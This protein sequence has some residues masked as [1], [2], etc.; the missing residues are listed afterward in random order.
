M[1]I[2]LYSMS[3]VLAAGLT[4]AYAHAVLA[5]QGYIGSLQSALLLTAGVAGLFAGVQLAY[6]T[7]LNLVAPSRSG[8]PLFMEAVSNGASVVLLPYLLGIAIPWPHPKLAEVEVLVLLAAF[9]GLHAAVK[10]F[11]LFAALHV[12]PGYRVIA[13]PWAAGAFISLA[14]G[15]LCLQIFA[16][17]LRNH[18]VADAPP[19][20]DAMVD[21]VH[22]QA[23]SVQEGAV[24]RI[25]LEGRAGKPLVLHVAYPEGA[26]R[27]DRVFF[28][29]ETDGANARPYN[30]GLTLAPA[31]WSA[32]RVT[33]IPRDAT[34]C[35]I[36]WAREQ[37][38]AW[39]TRTGV[40]PVALG[41]EQLLI[42]GP[43]V[44]EPAQ[45]P[46]PKS[47][48]L[49]LADGVGTRHT[50]LAEY[51]RETTPKLQ[52]WG[53]R[54]VAFT[55][56]MTPSP[57]APAT[58]MSI[59]S[60][61]SPLRHGFM[62]GN[63][64]GIPETQTM[65][66]QMLAARGYICAAFSEAESTAGP[67]VVTRDCA[68][69][70]GFERGFHLFDQAYPMTPGVEVGGKPIPGAFVPAGS[71]ATLERAQGFI[72][73]HKDVPF[74]VVIRLRELTAPRAVPGAPGGF[75]E[76]GAKPRPVDV[77]DSAL[78]QLDAALGD[79]LGWLEK[80]LPPEQLCVA[81]TS[82]F[83]YDFNAAPNESTPVFLNEACLRVPLW[84]KTQ[85]VEPRTQRT[86]VS[87]ED[88]GPTL[89]GVAGARAGNGGGQDLLASGGGR[90]PISATGDPVALS[91]RG[92]QWR[93]TM[94]T[95]R[96][97]ATRAPVQP[98]EVVEF[99]NIADYD[100]GNPVTNQWGK[101][102]RLASQYRQRLMEYV[103][104]Q[105]PLQGASPAGP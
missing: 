11:S 23:R 56:C 31:G 25:P 30:E 49:V 102:S 1:F 86:P 101:E 32:F 64:P 75:V 82:P 76:K 57:E 99:I 50:G 46:R 63:T 5:A 51:P 77:Y 21:L 20:A 74:F 48:V 72:A 83:G 4:G 9:L 93:L 66:P 7:L 34:Y 39:M 36:I 80:E 90:D 37:E 14:A 41:A 55:A 19:L 81:V 12:R 45:Q 104:T 91:V 100:K 43:H 89:A 29:V 87:L 24:F 26:S 67:R 42:A 88:L 52:A 18:R 44:V 65:L 8:A 28:S 85:G 69:G 35:D 62:N 2:A 10:L 16:Y 13:L 92:R 3:L 15:A 53:Q 97:F 58:M 40:R 73:A 17:Q 54:A 98:E 84:I 70:S 78:R 95:G 94:Q 47:I 60:G 27:T 71:S 38:P 33:G 59:L 105:R 6:M 103:E 96:S 22:T 79:F 68:F 61:V